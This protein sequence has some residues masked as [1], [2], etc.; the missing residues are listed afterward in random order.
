M[1][2]TLMGFNQE[3]VV[4]LCLD[5]TDLCILRWFIDFQNTKKMKH[6]Y[7]QT[8]DTVMYQVN[9]DAVI[10][11]LPILGLRNND[12]VY[13]RFG[14][15]V[16]A[17]LLKHETLRSGGTFAYYCVTEDAINLTYQQPNPTDEKPNPT[18]EKSEGYGWKVGGGTDGKS[19]QNNSSINYPSINTI[20]KILKY[21]KNFFD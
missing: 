21:L 4:S 5:M 7:F 19:E 6:H 16:N 11:D 1:K 10:E 17:G 18:D 2:Y 9:Y 3:K 20:R 8:L 15:L 12:S 14:K 13:R